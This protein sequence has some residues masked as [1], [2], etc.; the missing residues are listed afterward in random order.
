MNLLSALCDDPADLVRLLLL[1]F[2]AALLI[3]VW[4]TVC[5]VDHPTPHDGD[6]MASPF[7]D[8]PA[9]RSGEAP[10]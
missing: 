8:V 6:P 3:S 7:G 10:R 5:L 4:L 1:V 2:A 9:P